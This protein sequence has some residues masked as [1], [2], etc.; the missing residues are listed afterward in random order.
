MENLN[1][2]DLLKGKIILGDIDY[3]KSYLKN[4]E[5][6][7][8]IQNIYQIENKLNEEDIT[9]LLYICINS[10]KLNIFNYFY[11]EH[12]F[13]KDIYY[14]CRVYNLI[15]QKYDFNLFEYFLEKKIFFEIEDFETYFKDKILRNSYKYNNENQKKIISL[16]L[17][18]TK[19]SNIEY[20]DI[21]LSLIKNNNSCNNDIIYFIFE[22]YFD[23]HKLEKYYDE[24]VNVLLS[25]KNTILN[26]KFLKENG[27]NFNEN[28]E[29]PYIIEIFISRKGTISNDFFNYLI[30]NESFDFTKI[31]TNK[32]ESIFHYIIIYDFDFLEVISKKYKIYELEDESIFYTF[33]KYYR[34]DEKHYKVLNKFL[35]KKVE[36]E[37]INYILRYL[38]DLF[39]SYDKINNIENEDEDDEYENL[40]DE[41]IKE[42]NFNSIDHIICFNQYNY[43]HKSLLLFIERYNNIKYDELII[44]ISIHNVN[45]RFF[46]FLIDKLEDLNNIKKYLFPFIMLSHQ[47][48][49][50]NLKYTKSNK[51]KKIS[52][53][54]INN[55]YQNIYTFLIEKNIDLNFNETYNCHDLN[56][57][58]YNRFLN[59]KLLN[60]S[61]KDESSN[62]NN[63]WIEFN[64][65]YEEN[66]NIMN[67]IFIPNNVDKLFLFMNSTSNYYYKTCFLQK[68]KQRKLCL[69]QIFFNLFYTD[70]DNFKFF[71]K[72]GMSISLEQLP[73]NKIFYKKPI[74]YFFKYITNDYLIFIIMDIK[75]IIRDVNFF[76]E[77]C[78]FNKQKR[79]G[80]NHLQNCKD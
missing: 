43:F 66:I 42:D 1:P 47:D 46:K 64:K 24:L 68:K 22:N 76:K 6:N 72:K 35:E 57:I 2:L 60:H 14:L 27:Y 21:I 28:R 80:K 78:I 51:S 69:V 61:L 75:K 5:T 17:K 37:D 30:E 65:Y 48:A 45:F 55:Y 25:N 15:I 3:I 52:S 34:Y 41:N 70:I 39:N 36:I 49:L 32:H 74:E 54:T 58:E 23:I 33:I 38:I 26:Y 79:L 73:K 12:L 7:K 20:K 63:K 4:N 8:N 16:L 67:Y 10:G 40:E 62:N 31:Y 18:F 9:F 59:I 71:M 29:L 50:Y 19:M 53:K 56:D 13:E 77:S 11:N 44:L